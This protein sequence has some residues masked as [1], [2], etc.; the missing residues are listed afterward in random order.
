[1][2]IHK[3]NLTIAN[4]YLVAGTQPVLVDSGGPSSYTAIERALQKLD[5]RLQD[6][7]LII[8]THGHGDHVGSTAELQQRYGIPTALHPA[9]WA[10][11]KQ[12]HNRPF[13]YT[14]LSARLIAPFVNQPFQPFTRS[15]AIDD[16]FSLRSYGIPATVVHTPGH[17][18]GSIS[19]LFDDGAAIVGDLLMGGHL[20]GALLP[21]VPRRHYF[22][23]DEVALSKS[24]EQL[25][26]R[27]IDHFYVGHGGPL[28]RKQIIEHFGEPHKT[29]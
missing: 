12:G 21:N 22:Y 26:Q 15:L 8:H 19:L 29:S 10:M 25:L 6:I 24:M 23:E 11:T 4:A 28:H 18:A 9:D 17:T 13:S 20:G 27:E 7:A 14:R 16:S 3:L 5:I 1:M 2:M